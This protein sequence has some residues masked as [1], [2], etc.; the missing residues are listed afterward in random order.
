VG[1]QVHLDREQAMA[2]LKELVA[3]DLVEPSYV[4]IFEKMPKHY[5][6]QI[7]CNYNRDKIIEFAKNK[8]LTIM[9]DNQQKYLVIYKV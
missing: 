5:Q 6:I 2:M 1:G 4:H 9:E 7:K 3:K 8:Q